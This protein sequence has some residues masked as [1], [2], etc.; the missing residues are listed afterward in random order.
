ML[1]VLAI[2]ALAAGVAWSRLPDRSGGVEAASRRIETELRS[3]RAAARRGGADV[4]VAF[5]LSERTLLRDGR[6]VYSW[7]ETIDLRVDVAESEVDGARYAVRFAA[8]G[9]STGL[10]ADIW[11]ADGA[12]AQPPVRLSASWLTGEVRRD[13]G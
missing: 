3:A 4:R 6:R 11:A 1:V 10:S 12:G 9:G 2:L 13:P 8:S 7:P 5:D